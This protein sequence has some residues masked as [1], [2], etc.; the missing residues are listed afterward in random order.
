MQYSRLLFAPLLLVLAMGAPPPA[1]TPAHV[2]YVS[3]TGKRGAAGTAEAP[4]ASLAEAA[5]RARAGDVIR[6]GPG[7]YREGR[8]IRLDTAG[9]EKQ[10]IRIEA[11]EM[12]RPV[13]DFAEQPENEKGSRGLELAGD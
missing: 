5:T 11:A 13:L 8:T 9:I 12:D 2:W 7:T 10:P 1:A 3:T 6:V 4:L